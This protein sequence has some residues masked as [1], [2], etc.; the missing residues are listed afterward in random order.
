MNFELRGNS[1][2]YSSNPFITHSLNKY[3]L[4]NYGYDIVSKDSQFNS[5][6]FVLKI[7]FTDL[8][9]DEVSN[10]SETLL[11]NLISLL[12]ELL[13]KATKKINLSNQTKLIRLLKKILD[14]TNTS[15]ELSI[16][17]F[18]YDLHVENSLDYVVTQNKYSRFSFNFPGS[19]NLA[20][21]DYSIT[22]PTGETEVFDINK[23]NNAIRLYKPH[24]SLNWFKI[25]DNNKNIIEYLNKPKKAIFLSK[26]KYIPIKLTYKGRK[27][28]PVI[29]PPLINKGSF[30]KNSVMKK[31]WLNLSKDLHDA[32]QIIFYG[33]S[34][35]ESDLETLNVFS[36]NIIKSHTLKNITIINPDFSVCNRIIGSTKFSKLSYYKSIEGYLKDE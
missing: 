20:E 29:I 2:V 26:R 17:S 13:S 5:L 3:F 7:L 19:Y 9:I 31:I 10:E 28:F 11:Y 16:I 25:I 14:N 35:P 27:I 21:E 12:N 24:G 33:Y 8:F 18:N 32:E 1:R 4:S 15:E 22:N 6:E 36:R 23:D 30:I 34:L